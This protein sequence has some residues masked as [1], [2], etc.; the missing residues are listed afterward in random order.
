VC[1]RAAILSQELP[2][3]KFERYNLRERVGLASTRCR[4]SGCGGGDGEDKGDVNRELIV[5]SFW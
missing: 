5:P 2:W 1:V 3:V 4:A